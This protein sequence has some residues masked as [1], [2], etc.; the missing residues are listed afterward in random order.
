MRRPTPE[1]RRERPERREIISYIT[2]RCN[3]Y[4]LVVLF[5]FTVAC[6]NPA[7]REQESGFGGVRL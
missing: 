2:A 3:Y 7:E 5:C 4:V 6:N 1:H